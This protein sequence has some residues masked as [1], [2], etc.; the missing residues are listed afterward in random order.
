MEEQ[1][2]LINKLLEVNKIE[3]NKN[4]QSNPSFFNVLGRSYDEDLISRMLAYILKND[5]NLVWELLEYWRLLSNIGSAD[6][7]ICPKDFQIKSVECEKSMLNGRAD[8]FVLATDIKLTYT[9]TIENKI[10]SWE[11]DGQTQTYYDFVSKNYSSCQ[12]EYYQNAFLF[13][14]PSFNASPVSCEQFKIICY[15]DLLKRISETNDYRIN[16][17]K[18]HIKE[19]LTLGDIKLTDVDRCVLDNLPELRSILN[20]TESKLV[21]FKRQLFNELCCDNAIKGLVYN[22]YVWKTKNKQDRDI[23]WNDFKDSKNLVVEIAD[24]E[25]SFRIYKANE[26]YCDKDENGYYF[27]AELKFDE[28]NPKKILFQEVVKRYG[29]RADLSIVTKFME[30][31]DF[32]IN[33]ENRAGWWDG[34]YYVFI[35]KKFETDFEVL[36]NEWQEELSLF[37]KKTLNEY[38]AEMTIIFGKFKEW[39]NT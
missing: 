10:Y 31:G 6:K 4:L 23:Y 36:S 33:T 14:K 12:N 2:A 35:S 8:I 19:Y 15:N 13:L 1:C 29:N 25:T 38:I 32:G 9:L 34:Q 16:D 11:H 28:N 37:A 24:N 26:W 27:Y 3:Q 22:P 18:K 20:S 39:M 30:N 21:S 7:A 5:K 17:L